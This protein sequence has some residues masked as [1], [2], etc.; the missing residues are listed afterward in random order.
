MRSCA[1]ADVSDFKYRDVKL[2]LLKLGAKLQNLVKKFLPAIKIQT[3]YRNTKHRLN[4]HEVD[5]T[6]EDADSTFTT[7]A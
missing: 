7:E 5:Y 2:F 6:R 4:F 3:K 1:C